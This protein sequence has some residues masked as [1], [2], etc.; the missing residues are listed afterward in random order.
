MGLVGAD[1]VADARCLH[2]K[3]PAPAGEPFCCTGCEAVHQALQGAGLQDWYRLREVDR[4]AIVGVAAR[5]RDDR[6]Y[7]YLD[8]D[9][10]RQQHCRA[11]GGQGGYEAAW[12][13]DGM[14]CVACAWL[15][16][17]V[18]RKHDGVQEVRVDL[19]EQRM[20]LRFGEGA[21]LGEIAKEIGRFGYAVALPGD[22]TDPGAARRADLVDI[23]VAGALMGNTML[24]V[25]PYYAGLDT[26]RFAILFGWL[27]MLLATVSLAVPG[28]IFLR[29]AWAATRM[30]MIS[31][32]VPIAIG[33]CAAWLYSLAQ[34]VRGAYDQLYLDSLVMLVFSLRVGRFFQARTVERATARTRLLAASM[35]DL[36]HVLRDGRWVE[37]A[38]EQI[39]VGETV[40]VD[41]GQ[42]LPADGRLLRDAEVDLQVVSG[43]EAPR[44]LRAGEA[45]P[46]GA[47]AVDLA[48][49]VEVEQP[50]PL[51]ASPTPAAGTARRTPMLADRIGAIFTAVIIVAAA[52]GFAYWAAHG[53]LG[54]GLQVAMVVLI[55]A[56]PCALGLATPTA[57]ALAIADAARHGV[58]IRE[59]SVI[60]RLGVLR[61]VVFDKTGTVTE[62][63]P[64]VERS[65]WA[66]QGG[67]DPVVVAA[68]AD[69]EA[70][71]RHPIA[72]GVV[73]FLESYERE[74]GLQ[75][76]RQLPE[77]VEVEAGSGIR[78]A[79]RGLHVAAR[80][81]EGSTNNP[82]L[83]AFVEAARRDGLSVVVLT[84][85]DAAIGA[86]GLRDALRADAT[87]V[88]AALR[89][90]GLHVELL[91][92]DH[93]VAVAAV[94]ARLHIAAATGDVRPAEKAARIEAL[95]THGPVAMVG[96]GQ[97][98]VLAL[99]GASLA[100][101]LAGATP[102]AIGASEIVLQSGGLGGIRWL[103]EKARRTRSTIRA[104]LAFAAVYNLLGVSWALSGTLTPLIAAVL[105][106]L[107]SASVVAIAVAL[108]RSSTT[109]A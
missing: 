93:P 38:A 69:V 68:L 98:D 61:S 4:D 13:V 84:R 85:D 80:A 83:D 50:P 17:E 81:A 59:P 32:D 43:E 48:F 19:L 82:T 41:P 86:L 72:R 99:E 102:S 27:S 31:L 51:L 75:P 47:R 37:V 26:G 94:A 104:T 78:G 73:R 22:A 15:I 2:C 74:A 96:D 39:T 18:A 16:E 42:R 6:A 30:R 57:V 40:R 108:S 60:E 95:Q 7:G 71:S 67:A 106:P 79:S 49:E 89:G 24:L 5:P 88:V 46:A 97:N 58:L 1:S 63:R 12:A 21:P 53:G 76:R 29:N 70:T 54:T 77:S 87:E 66:G 55:V 23:G 8:T 14:T 3:G 92:G 33:L 56:C 52:G 45:L 107:S 105:M 10:Y 28:R 44:R 9:A 34:L 62:G 100:V 103:L 36:V 35:P 65:A 20:E 90:E 64:E 109:K 11:A 91:S 101:T 25:L